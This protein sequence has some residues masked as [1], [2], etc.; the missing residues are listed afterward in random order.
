LLRIT[1]Y[2]AWSL[3]NTGYQGPAVEKARQYVSSHRGEKADAYTLAVL[4]NFAVDYGRDR[5]FTRQAMQLLL[6]ART[7]QGEQLWWSA[8]ET[9][10]CSTGESASVETTGLALQAL[11]KWAA[12]SGTVRKAL[13]YLTAKKGASGMGHNAGDDHGSAGPP[14][15]N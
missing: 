15:G 7:E 12:A 5:E 6:D 13:S 9:G 1:S 14:P 2:L 8:D 10:V 3:D 11:L 4:A